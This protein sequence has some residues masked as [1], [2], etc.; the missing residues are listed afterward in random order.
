MMNFKILN[1]GNCTLFLMT[2]L[3]VGALT[4]CQPDDTGGGAESSG[5][6]SIESV[7]LTAKD[8]TTT[9][10]LR[11]NSY[12]IYGNN[13]GTTQEVYFNGTKA[14]FNPT[15]VTNNVIITS[16]PEDAPYFDASD[17]LRVVTSKGEATIPFSIEQP[18]PKIISFAPLAASAGDIVT[19]KGEIFEGLESVRFGDT[20]AEIV[21]S[22]TTEIQVRVPEGVVQAFLF[23]ETA[24]GV[25][26]S[27]Q[28]FGFKFVIYDDALADSWWIGGWAG[29][30]DFENTERV[31]RGDFSIKRTYEGGYSGFQIG[32]GGATIDLST[33]SA[34]KVSIY[35]GEGIND[36][37][38]VLNGND[39]VGK[40]I[41]IEEG[42]WNDFTIPLS[43]L[44]SPAVLTEFWVQEFS[45][46]VP[47]V[48]YIDDLGLI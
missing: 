24:G 8:S 3:F 42:V 37:K 36:V 13:L 18:A 11:Q 9:V 39:G 40:V 2:L 10:G 32:N 48:V 22:T 4:S 46:T 15:L 31:K 26:Q 5:P 33:M 43:E 27:T 7:A 23:V 30:Q 38:I 34:V 6:P 47:A 35:G 29:T 28:S 21:S 20:E 44:G 16:I 25:S 1:Q 45:G 41:T 12:T 17:E 19:I 14:Y